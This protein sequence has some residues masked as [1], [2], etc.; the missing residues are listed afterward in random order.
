MSTSTWRDLRS[1]RHDPPGH[2]NGNGRGTR[3]ATFQAALEQCEQFVRAAGGADPATRPLQLFYAMSQGTRAVVTASPR[4]G[5]NWRIHGHGL[6]TVTDT[7]VLPDVTVSANGDG[8]FQALARVL[9]FPALVPQ[10]HVRLGDLWPMIPESI[11]APLDKTETLSAIMFWPGP[12]PPHHRVYTAKL[13]WVRHAVRH[14]YDRDQQ[15]LAQHFARYPALRGLSWTAGRD[16]PWQVHDF[17]AN[18]DVQFELVDG[19]QPAILQPGSRLGAR[20]VGQVENEVFITPPAGSMTGPL[21]PIL[22]WWAVLLALSSLARYEPASW[23]KM[24]DVNASPH[25]TA[26]EHLLDEAIGQIPRMLLSM[27]T[28]I[29]DPG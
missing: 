15:G 17:A 14:R 7:T 5:A 2:A 8:L 25:A 11:N 28:H 4:I 21:H 18:L 22:A 10:E 1:L 19:K 16:V 23:V 3:R 13:A 20:Y 24:I 27:L 9:D 6:S 26:I 29:D 12:W